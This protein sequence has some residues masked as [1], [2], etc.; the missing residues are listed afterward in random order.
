[1]IAVWLRR[2]RSINQLSGL[3]AIS[4]IGVAWSICVSRLNYRSVLTQV[5]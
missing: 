2:L 4:A 5:D 3:M 1:M